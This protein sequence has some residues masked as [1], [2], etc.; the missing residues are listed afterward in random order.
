LDPHC[1]QKLLDAGFFNPH[2]SHTLISAIRDSLDW[3]R[4]I[5]MH[6]WKN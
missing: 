6:F 5:L 3:I 1:S 2:F 4:R